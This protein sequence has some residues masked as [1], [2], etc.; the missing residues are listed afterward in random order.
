M[1]AWK[2]LID[3]T[4][5]DIE[6]KRA[7][8]EAHRT[9]DPVPDGTEIP[10]APPPQPFEAVSVQIES[11]VHRTSPDSLIFPIDSL[12]TLLCE[13][14]YT[15]QQDANMG[16]DPAWHLTLFSQL[17]VSRA[18]I[19]HV[20]ERMLEAQEAPFTGRRRKAVIEW[21]NTAVDAWLREADR[22]GLGT[23]KGESGLGLWVQELVER[24]EQVVGEIIAEVAGN[25]RARAEAEDL[26]RATRSTKTK[27]TA[28]LRSNTPGSLRFR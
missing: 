11:I 22:K 25:A 10:T 16:A 17:G 3:G 9:G 23:G 4:H 18:M 13:Y 6:E 27:V 28:A 24:A 2:S 1:D 20:L 7:A 14:A 8:Y 12:L 26:L 19:V 21:I 15:S 5:Q